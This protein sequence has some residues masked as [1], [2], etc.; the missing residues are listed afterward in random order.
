MTKFFHRLGKRQQYRKLQ[1]IMKQDKMKI[2]QEDKVAMKEEMQF[3]VYTEKGMKNYK[4]TQVFFI[5]TVLILVIINPT[6][7]LQRGF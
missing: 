4:G 5:T 7:L 3:Q 6:N 1:K 2:F